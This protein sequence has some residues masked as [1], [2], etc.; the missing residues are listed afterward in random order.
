[1]EE[2]NINGWVRSHRKMIKWKWYKDPF[3]KAVFYHCILL[4]N[5]EDGV[6]RKQE[7]KRGQLITSRETIAEDNGMSVQQVRTCLN[8]LA[9]TN[10]LIVETTNHYTKI[11]VVNYEKY[12]ANSSTPATS[13]LTRV[14]TSKKKDISTSKKTQE[15]IDIE[16][17]GE[18]VD[19]KS[20][21]QKSNISTSKNEGVATSKS[22]STLTTNKNNIINNI[23]RLDYTKLDL[24]FNYLIYREEE[25]FESLNAVDRMSICS[26]L[27]NLEIL[28]T[29]PTIQYLSEDKLLDL[30]LQYWAI[31]ELYVNPDKVY[32]S[33]LSNSNFMFK[34]LKAKKYKTI[35][36][37][38]DLCSFVGYF[39]TCLREVMQENRGEV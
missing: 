11:T 14:A 20:T 33:K 26:I 37:E 31:T 30:K 13:T 27:K 39:I 5:H 10:D 25:N 3:V 19:I 6:W 4:A 17:V 35:E 24:L 16:E 22:T 38:E 28:V 15:N 34:F 8:K 7:V 18:N 2:N 32:L 29:I 21:S 9:S 12:Q 1:M 36:K 23:Y